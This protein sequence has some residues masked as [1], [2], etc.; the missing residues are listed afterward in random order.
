MDRNLIAKLLLSTAVVG[1]STVGCTTAGVSSSSSVSSASSAQQRA[2]A[3]AAKA[4]AAMAKG[5]FDEALGFAEA[6][7]EQ[8]MTNGQ[9]RD[10]LARVYLAQGRFASAE[11]T[12][13]DVMELGQVDPRTVVSLALARIAQGKTASAISLMEANSAIVPAGDY[14]LTLALA[15]QSGQAIG[16]LEQAI[17]A[18]GGTARSRQNLAL[19]YALDGRWQDA[20]VVASQDMSQTDVS[21]R[22]AQW[23]QYARP[24]AYESR[25]AGLLNV[26]PRADAGQPVRL[27]LASAPAS[28]AEAPV[29]EQP[30]SVASVS[31]A[32]LAAVGPAPTADADGFAAVESDV[33]VAAVE[34]SEV[35]SAPLIEAPT[36]PA[37]LADAP[38]P[39]KAIGIALATP[40]QVAA[41]YYAQTGIKPT[42][43]AAAAKPAKAA[44]VKMALAETA[45]AAASKAGG[46]HVVQLGA[47][48]STAAAG[49]AW[50]RYSR[51]Y[52]ALSGYSSSNST[53]TVGGKK[54]VRLAAAGFDSA[55]QANSVCRAIKSKGGDCV[56][57]AADSQ[58]VRF[59]SASG[60]INAR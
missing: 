55:A 18:D 2:Q 19:A 58:P 6:A 36:V 52:S 57:K 10:T 45:P 9:Y 11:R 5:R 14:G 34:P 39:V 54:L 15:G 40:E 49:E 60:K 23:A 41:A 31:E 4:E 37:K 30:V 50:S 59:A 29:F 12:L 25:V 3:S 26:T 22:I 13:M 35:Y 51:Q 38:A 53:A 42:A 33:T 56:V 28:F 47:F 24:N 44:P 46:T 16:V 7:V 20:R 21:T 48:S 17:R 43:P 27:A 8:D 1:T 32:E